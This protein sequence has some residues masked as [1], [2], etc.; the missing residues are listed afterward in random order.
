MGPYTAITGFGN[1]HF[2]HSRAPIDRGVGH[3]SG[4]TNEQQRLARSK[5]PKGDDERTK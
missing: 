2:D 5:N 4:V 1:A 3:K